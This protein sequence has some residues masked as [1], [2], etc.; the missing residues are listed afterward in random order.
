MVGVFVALMAVPTPAAAQITQ[1]AS[2][3][4]A[5]L[6]ELFTELKRCHSADQAASI[7]NEIWQIWRR[8]GD[9]SVDSLFDIG[10]VAMG[11]RD[12]DRALEIF[13]EITDRAPLFAEGWNKLATVHYLRGELD[14]ALVD[15]DR[16]I[17]LEQRHFG[18]LTGRAMILLANGNAAGALRLYE[19]AL[20]INPSSTRIRQEV[21]RL[22]GKLGYRSV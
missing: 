15:V 19:Q 18:A 17:D 6:D 3:S 10:L 13:T 22:R 11:Y 21:E 4:T 9:P 20:A 2:S 7:E 14:D 8:S 16:A 5:R 1:P 12:M